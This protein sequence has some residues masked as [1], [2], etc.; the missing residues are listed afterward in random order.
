MTR[1]ETCES[2]VRLVFHFG[3]TNMSPESKRTQPLNMSPSQPLWMPLTQQKT[4]KDEVRENA[5]PGQTA[6]TKLDSNTISAKARTPFLS[7]AHVLDDSENHTI[8]KFLASTVLEGGQTARRLH[9]SHTVTILK[10]KQEFIETGD[11]RCLLL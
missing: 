8:R 7:K 4:S 1:T 10:A 6:P 9:F 11:D 5:A 2:Q 3:R